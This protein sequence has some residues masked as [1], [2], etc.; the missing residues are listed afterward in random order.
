MSVT[1]TKYAVAPDVGRLESAIAALITAGYQPSG[2]PTVLNGQ[3][4]QRMD[5]SDSGQIAAAGDGSIAIKNG[6]VVITKG[7]AAALTLAA[8]T[9]EQ[10]GIRI[11]VISQTAFAH[12]ITAT[13][14]ID[15]GVTGG[16]KDTA[17]FAAFAG[18][19]IELE[20]VNLKWA[21]VSKNVVTIFG[22]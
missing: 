22:S 20:A 6:T 2:D 9:A 1:Q 14:L 10:A 12:V 21:V 3:Y 15:D 16:A 18:A 17:T 11:R 8:P 7:S 13:N 4:V 5:K 19:A